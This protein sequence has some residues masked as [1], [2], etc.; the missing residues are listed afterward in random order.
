MPGIFWRKSSRKKSER[1][2][3]YQCGGSADSE[4]LVADFAFRF[5]AAQVRDIA[6]LAKA[7]ALSPR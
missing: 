6:R 4:R 1:L 3:E 5:L 7:L 2:Q